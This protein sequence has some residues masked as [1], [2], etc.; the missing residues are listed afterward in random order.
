MNILIE[1][2]LGMLV[3]IKETYKQVLSIL[4]NTI[5]SIPVLN[6]I[7]DG[8]QKSHSGLVKRLKDVKL[9]WQCKIAA[10]RQNFKVLYF[11]LWHMHHHVK[12]A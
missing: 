8:I 6:S 7:K 10:V 2:S 5:I 1:K 11:V 9:S 12:R 4:K 3:W